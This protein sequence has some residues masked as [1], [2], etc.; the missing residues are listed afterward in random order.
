MGFSKMY[1]ELTEYSTH[2]CWVKIDL[3]LV[4]ITSFSPTP[5]QKIY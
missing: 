5:F 1:K 3:F 2:L 4:E